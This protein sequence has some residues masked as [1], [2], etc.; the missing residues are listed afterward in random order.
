MHFYYFLPFLSTDFTDFTDFCLYHLTKRMNLMVAQCNV[1]LNLMHLVIILPPVS[2]VDVNCRPSG[3][4]N[5]VPR[6]AVLGGVL[7]LSSRTAAAVTK[8]YLD[9]EI[10]SRRW[11]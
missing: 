1:W 7:L 8:Q 11:S 6:L 2:S 9:Y 10:C 4:L 5:S 3:S